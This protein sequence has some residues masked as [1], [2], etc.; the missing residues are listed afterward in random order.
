MSGAARGVVAASLGKAQVAIHGEADHGGV[1]VVLA[2]VLPPADGTKRQSAGSLK[3]FATAT[4]TAI[5]R[6]CSF[7][8]DGVLPRIDGRERRKQVY[9]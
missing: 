9:R 8:Q 6:I 7:S 2:V 5:A 4:R 1:A 3:R